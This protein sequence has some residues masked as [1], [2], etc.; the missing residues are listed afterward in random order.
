MQ[1]EHAFLDSV[2]A[3]GAFEGIDKILEGAFQSENGVGFEP[4]TDGNFTLPD[5]LK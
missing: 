1:E 4:D 5:A 2:A 3:G